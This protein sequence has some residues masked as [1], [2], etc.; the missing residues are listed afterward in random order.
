LACHDGTHM[1]FIGR[2]AAIHH[3]PSIRFLFNSINGIL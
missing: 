1:T 3:I 2:F